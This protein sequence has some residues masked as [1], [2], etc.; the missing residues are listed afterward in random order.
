MRFHGIYCI[1][2]W[3]QSCLVN[4]VTAACSACLRTRTYC[5][6][7][8][9]RNIEQK[10][11]LPGT[12]LLLMLALLLLATSSVPHTVRYAILLDYTL[13]RRQTKP[14][15]ALAWHMG[16]PAFGRHAAAW[17]VEQNTNNSAVLR[18]ALPYSITT[19]ATKQHK[20]LRL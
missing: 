7:R 9:S 10:T 3:K 12:L 1:N 18:V 19:L 15:T 4:S 2:R 20:K 8:N 17:R 13:G 11:I 6:T 5:C 16:G 14:G